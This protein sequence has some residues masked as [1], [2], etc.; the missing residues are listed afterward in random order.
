MTYDSL[1]RAVR[2]LLAGAAPGA[3]PGAGMAD[4]LC[5]HL[6]TAEEAQRR[7]DPRARAGALT[8]YANQLDA[9]V[10]RRTLSGAQAAALKA[11]ADQLGPEGQR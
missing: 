7:G 5:V 3:A 2:E 9:L 11:L 4:A 10:N 8:A 6:R 1:C